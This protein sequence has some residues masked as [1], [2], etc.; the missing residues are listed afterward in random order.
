MEAPLWN[1]GASISISRIKLVIKVQKVFSGSV[2]VRLP[3]LVEFVASVFVF[4]WKHTILLLTVFIFSISSN[5]QLLYLLLPII[6]P[7]IVIF[8]FTDLLTC[9]LIT[10][11]HSV[12]NLFIY[13]MKIINRN[14]FIIPQISTPVVNLI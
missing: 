11:L 6:A 3:D 14:I 7:S 5:F 10:T 9:S 2:V 1:K 4:Q 13:F 8:L 12:I